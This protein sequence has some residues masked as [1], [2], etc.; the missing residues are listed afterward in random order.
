MLHAQLKKMVLV[1]LLYKQP[2]LD[3][4]KHQQTALDQVQVVAQDIV[5]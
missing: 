3:M 4:D 1:A 2:V 5:Q